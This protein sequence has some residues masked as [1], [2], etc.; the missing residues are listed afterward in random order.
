MKDAYEIP[1]SEIQLLDQLGAGNFGEVWE[2]IL[3][4]QQQLYSGMSQQHD[5]YF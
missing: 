5:I 2:G 4:D 1:K 3:Y